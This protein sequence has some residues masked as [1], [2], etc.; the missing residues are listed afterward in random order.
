MQ[1]SI[2]LNNAL[3]Y[4][5]TTTLVGSLLIFSAQANLLGQQQDNPPPPDNYY[6]PPPPPQGKVIPPTPATPTDIPT[7]EELNE[8]YRRGQENKAAEKLAA[9]ERAK[10]KAS[11]RRLRK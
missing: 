3:T 1:K 7:Q 10:A 11:T 2:S 5:C 9:A 4:I 8:A 6:V